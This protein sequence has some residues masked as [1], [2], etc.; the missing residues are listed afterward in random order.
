MIFEAFKQGDGE[1]EKIINRNIEEVKKIICA[2]DVFSCDRSIKTVLCGGMVKQKD[3]LKP[4]LQ[5]KLGE[6][7]EL[8]FSE[9]P[10]VNGAIAIAGGNI[11]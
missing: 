4:I 8:F 2:G 7:Y 6:R 10:M 1:A 3:I 9:E 5:E 11:C